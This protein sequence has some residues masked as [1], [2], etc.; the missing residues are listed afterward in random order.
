MR[1][2]RMSTRSQVFRSPGPKPEGIHKTMGAHTCMLP[3]VKDHDIV[4]T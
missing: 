4:I 2:S 1:V 3:S